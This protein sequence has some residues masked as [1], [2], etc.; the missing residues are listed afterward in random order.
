M[1][2]VNLTPHVVTVVDEDARVIRTWPGA[3]DPAR[4][5]A[6]RVPMGHLDD[7]KCRGLVPLIVER[8]TRANLPEPR[9]GVW[10]IVSSVVGSAHPERDDLLIPSDLVR[11]KRGVVTACR[12]FVISG[13]SPKKGKGRA[14]EIAKRT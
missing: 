3:A 14:M 11:D 8:R 13:R 12:S 5:E 7:D 6:E 1:P 9:E 4:V 2:V 10:F